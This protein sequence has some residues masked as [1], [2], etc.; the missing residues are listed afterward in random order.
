MKAE[1]KMIESE[2]AT[3]LFMSSNYLDGCEQSNGETGALKKATL[4]ECIK[5]AEL[6]RV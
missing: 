6:F 3:D 1:L 2:S 5:K 4:L